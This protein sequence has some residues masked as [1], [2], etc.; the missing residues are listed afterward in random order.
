MAL[1]IQHVIHGQWRT[2][3][4]RVEHPADVSVTRYLDYSKVLSQMYVCVHTVYSKTPL[5]TVT[6]VY[7]LVRSE[8][9][10]SL[11]MLCRDRQK[12]KKRVRLRVRKDMLFKTKM[13]KNFPRRRHSPCPD[14][15][16][17][18]PHPTLLGLCSNSTPIPKSWIRHCTRRLSLSSS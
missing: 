15:Y 17:S 4:G 6:F 1:S 14:P 5:L 8:L 7:E 12:S 2:G 10:R 13:P 11:A 18:P 9:V 3:G 16:P